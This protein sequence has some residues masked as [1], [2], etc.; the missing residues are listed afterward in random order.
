MSDIQVLRRLGWLRPGIEYEV[1]DMTRCGDVCPVL[2]PTGRRRYTLFCRPVTPWL[3]LRE[4]GP[5]RPVNN[6]ALPSYPGAFE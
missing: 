4:P 3:P 6:P 1:R 2:Y 5:Y